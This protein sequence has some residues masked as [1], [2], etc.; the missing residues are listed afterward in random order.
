[1]AP[2]TIALS[3]YT[4]DEMRSH[5]APIDDVLQRLGVREGRVSTAEFFELW[6]QLQRRARPDLGLLLGAASPRRPFAITAAAVNAPNLGEALAI[7]ARF[8]RLTCPEDVVL[9]R[10][11]NGEASVRFL[12]L[13]ATGAVPQLL[14]DTVLASVAAL[15]KVGSHGRIKPVRIELSRRPGNA[16]ALRAHFGCQIC[17]SA[18]VDRIVFAERALEVPFVTANADA[19]ART[20]PGLET[21]LQT[22]RSALQSEVR[23]AIARS[24]TSGARPSVKEIAG[25]MQL[26]ARTLQRK[27]GEEQTSYQAELDRVRHASAR[28]L[29]ANTELRETEIAFFLGFEEP[30]SFIRAFRAW[31]RTTPRKWR[32]RTTS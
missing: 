19:F 25:T 29:L 11:G 10:L 9:D 27:L 5:G 28:R 7:V 24:I 22:R 18:E 20:I 32:E 23:M 30:N 15:A 4:L 26:S 12:W 14:V 1:M 16:Q 3:S 13:L 17:F 21:Q 2:D 8:K 6:T 31:E